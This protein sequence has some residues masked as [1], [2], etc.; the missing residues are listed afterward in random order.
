MTQAAFGLSVL[1][2]GHIAT[3]ERQ[4]AGLA[5]YA[6][7]YADGAADGLGGSV[8]SGVGSGI[9]SGVGISYYYKTPKGRWQIDSLLYP[10]GLMA[11][12]VT[13]TMIVA[14]VLIVRRA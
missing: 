9:G 14:W 8:G 4:R 7:G 5:G 12:L 11:L 1:T 6:E 10:E 13:V 3:S 2:V